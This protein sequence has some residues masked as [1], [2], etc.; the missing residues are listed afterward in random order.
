MELLRGENH[1]HLARDIG[2]SFEVLGDALERMQ[3]D[4]IRDWALSEFSAELRAPTMRI[5]DRS[6]RF[7]G[8]VRVGG[9]GTG[10]PSHSQ[11]KTHDQA[12]EIKWNA[13]I[14]NAEYV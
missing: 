7:R 6:S 13:R 3:R 10:Q 12:S 1:G 8:Y 2:K 11:R 14:D 5:D 4:K 9:N